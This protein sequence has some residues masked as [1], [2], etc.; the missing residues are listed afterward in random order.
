MRMIST[1]RLGYITTQMSRSA[2]LTEHNWR[3]LSKETSRSIRA[4]SCESKCEG[5]SDSNP[6][7]DSTRSPASAALF[8]PEICIHVGTQSGR[9]LEALAHRFSSGRA[10][11]TS[12]RRSQNLLGALQAGSKLQINRLPAREP[13]CAYL[14]YFLSRLFILTL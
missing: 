10:T 3:A 5:A 11:L 4:A 6:A 2:A 8:A 7:L 1:R 9:P 13:L 14:I 12:S